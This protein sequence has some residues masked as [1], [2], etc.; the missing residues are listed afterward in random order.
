MVINFLKETKKF[1][2]KHDDKLKKLIRLLKTKDLQDQ[3][4]IIFTEFADTAR[5]ISNELIKAGIEGVEEVDSGTK[6]NRGEIIQR[7]APYYNGSS[8]GQLAEEGKK[9]I[10]VLVSTDVLAE[11]LNLQDACRMM[12]YDIHWNP[13]RLMQRIGRVDRRMNP[14]IE[15]QLVTDHPEVADSRGKVTFWNFL[16]PDELNQILSLYTTVTKKTLLISKTLGIER[17]QLLTPD[18]KYD[19]LRE[20]N[21]AYE[22]KKTIVEEMHLEYQK[23]VE[24]DPDLGEHL[25]SL[26]GAIF[27]GRKRPAKGTW[28]V[29]FC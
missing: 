24:E 23:L 15:D 11:G 6:G 10:R 26:P 18:D 14:A 27:S 22:G 5:Y 16:P 8:S 21:Q 2:A 28:V 3:K 12:N 25:N 29:F 17:R 7:F 4:V 9:E 1:E 20:F 13:V 19:E